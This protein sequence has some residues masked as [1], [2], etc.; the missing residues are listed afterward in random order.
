MLRPKVKVENIGRNLTKTVRHDY[1]DVVARF[2]HFAH[3][4]QF[5]NVD[6]QT[7][8]IPSKVDVRIEKSPAIGI[9]EIVFGVNHDGSIEWLG[10]IVDSSD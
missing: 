9:G 1:D 4:S 2:S 5:S 6:F 3:F 10:E 8:T 7:K